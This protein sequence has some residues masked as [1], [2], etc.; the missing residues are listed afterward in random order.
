MNKKEIEEGDIKFFNF[1]TD[2]IFNGDI[3]INWKN[4]NKVKYSIKNLIKCV[5]LDRDYD[6]FSLIDNT[7][8]FIIFKWNNRS[9][10]KALIYVDKRNEENMNYMN[11]YNL[12]YK[13]NDNIDFLNFLNEVK[14]IN[15]K[16]IFK[17]NL[18]IFDDYN[19]IENKNEIL[20]INKENLYKCIICYLCTLFKP[21]YFNKGGYSSNDILLLDTLM[22]HKDYMNE[23]EVISN[24][25]NYTIKY[26]C[27]SSISFEY[28]YAKSLEEFI[29]IYKKQYKDNRINDYYDI[30]LNYIYNNTIINKRIE[31]IKIKHNLIEYDSL[32]LMLNKIINYN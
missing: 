9:M 27:F 3:I 30:N 10:Y 5:V 13:A 24:N 28:K 1:F 32:I 23:F 31:E 14:N 4:N 8:P 12:L 18:R 16:K 26:N 19:D 25:F 20:Y 22:N 17:E 2:E 21:L 15:K 7:Y 29:E 11:N 6:I